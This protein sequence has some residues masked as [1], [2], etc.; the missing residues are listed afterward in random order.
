MPKIIF[1]KI[2][3]VKPEAYNTLRSFSESSLKE[4]HQWN[5]GISMPFTHYVLFIKRGRWVLSV[6]HGSAVLFDYSYKQVL[7]VEPRKYIRE[8]KY[9]TYE[10]IRDRIV[11]T[12]TDGSYMDIDPKDLGTTFVLPEPPV[13]FYVPLHLRDI[14]NKIKIYYE[15]Y[16]QSVPKD[17]T[18]YRDCYTNR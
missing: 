9:D 10:E 7:L 16:V 3:V 6:S 4:T 13:P 1:P 11:L 8:A 15:V 12:L 18:C 2:I 17:L 5:T 14:I